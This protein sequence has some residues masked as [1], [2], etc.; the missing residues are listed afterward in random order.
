MLLVLLAA[1]VY[2]IASLSADAPN[3]IISLAILVF[4]LNSLFFGTIVFAWTLPR[5]SALRKLIAGA[6]A[7]CGIVFAGAG[8]PPYGGDAFPILINIKPQGIY[9]VVGLVFSVA[10]ATIYLPR[11]KWLVP[12]AATLALMFGFVMFPFVLWLTGGLNLAIATIASVVL[13]ALTAFMLYR[14][15]QR[16]YHLM[17]NERTYVS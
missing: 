3:V 12:Y 2:G 17:V 7:L 1:M 9:A 8:F 5:K 11:A 4:S 6:F 13:T 14:H 16:Q 10:A 15:L